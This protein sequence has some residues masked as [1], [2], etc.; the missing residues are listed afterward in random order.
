MPPKF[1]RNKILSLYQQ[2]ER[3]LHDLKTVFFELTGQCNLSCLHCGS[4]CKSDRFEKLDHA[5]VLETLAQIKSEYYS[6]R[7]NVIL[8]GGEPLCYPGVF[9]LGKQIYALEFP[10]GMVTNGYGWAPQTVDMARAS[11]LHSITVSLDGMAA[12]HNWLRG[13]NDAFARAS[14]TIRMLYN[15]PFFR[16]MDVVTC[17]NQ[18]NLDELDDLYHYL[19]SLGVTQWRLFVISPIGRAAGQRELFL[20][21]NQF[22]RLLDKIIQFRENG[23]IGVQLSES[24]FI[25]CNLNDSVRDQAFFCRAGISVAGIMMNGDIIACPNIDRRFKQ[26][27]VATDSFVDVWENKYE[28]F[29]NRRW[30]KTG[31]CKHC[32]QWGLCNGN[33]FHLWDIDRNQT[34]CC[35]YNLLNES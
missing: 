2:N 30:M 3:N 18:R 1:F 21:G 34:M 13:N 12:G 35:H 4:D 5:T 14:N 25:G 8:T 19:I 26:G 15:E 11:G 28:A 20:D 27:N 6:K 16:A 9:E 10:W 22:K 17:V 23:E 7:I 32:K 31:P 29:R 33:S 24:G